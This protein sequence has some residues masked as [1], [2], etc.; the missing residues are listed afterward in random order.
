MQPKVS[1]IIPVYNTAPYLRRCLDSVTQQTLEDIEIICVDDGS[2][3]DSPCILRQYAANDPRVVII[4]LDRQQG[5]A[6]ARNFALQMASGVYIGFIDSDDYIDRH[7]YDSLYCV[8]VKEKADIA[9]CNRKTIE[10]DGRVDIMKFNEAVIGNKY[11]FSK[12]FTTGIYI[13][14]MLK[15]HV[16]RFPNGITNHEDV[17]FLVK[18]VHWAN[19][20]ATVDEAWYYCEKRNDSSSWSIEYEK[21]LI[22]CFSAAVL[23]IDFLNT[24]DIDKESYLYI[25]KS[26]IISIYRQGCPQNSEDAAKYCLS[27]FS[28]CKYK[29][30][31]ITS[32]P[33]KFARILM[34]N[35]LPGLIDFYP[36]LCVKDVVPL[37]MVDL[38]R[39]QVRKSLF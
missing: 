21:R 13:R 7:Y 12:G 28:Q 33:S 25:V 2:T 14:T 20:I 16:I 5:A 19:K 24:V 1:V 10:I 9:K 23:I 35:D 29:D 6:S 39:T 8:A 27:L 37:K 30:E 17:V 26:E 18:A 22:S 34:R 11:K 31:F 3:D 38:L 4:K 32:L 15:H 36:Y